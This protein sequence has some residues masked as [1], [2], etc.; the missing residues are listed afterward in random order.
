MEEAID[1]LLS[2]QAN[3]FQNLAMNRPFQRIYI[4]EL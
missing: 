2:F 4:L 3:I 1:L